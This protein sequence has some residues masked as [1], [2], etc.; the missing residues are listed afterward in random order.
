MTTTNT[1]NQ[2]SKAPSHGVYTVR[3]RGEGK[4][5]FWIRIGSAWP[6]RDGKGFNVQLECHPLDDQ[7]TL[8]IE[9]EKQE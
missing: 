3:D 2:T 7:L 1:N 8:R 9:G 6:H 5:A 4:K